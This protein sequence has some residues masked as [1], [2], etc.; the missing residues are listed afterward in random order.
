MPDLA[1]LNAAVYVCLMR[2]RCA[3]EKAERAAER[4]DVR[5]C[6]RL[7]ARAVEMRREA[8]DTDPAHD[9]PA[10]ADHLRGTC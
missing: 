5:E 1:E 3:W 6:A 4:G 7:T 10:S 9:C 2:A 8:E